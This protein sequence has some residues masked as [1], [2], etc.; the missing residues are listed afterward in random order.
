[1]VAANAQEVPQRCDEDFC[2]VA[3]EGRLQMAQSYQTQ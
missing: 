1:M 3:A 2:A